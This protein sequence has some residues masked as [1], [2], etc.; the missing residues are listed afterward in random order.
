LA[1]R[2]AASVAETHHTALVLAANSNVAHEGDILGKPSSPSAAEAMLRRLSDSSHS[3]YTGMALQHHQS[4]RT[5]TTSVETTV[6]FGA[7]DEA[8]ITAYVETGSPM[9]KAGAYGIQ[10][11]TGPLFVD[12]IS[13]DYYNVVGLPLRRLYETLRTDFPELIDAT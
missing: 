8:E 1:Q 10:D 5:V 11:H 9:D 13:G 6:A 7:L 3:V 2:K 4:N 12:G